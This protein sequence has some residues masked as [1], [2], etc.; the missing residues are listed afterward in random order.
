MRASTTAGI[1][2]GN[3]DVASVHCL[4]EALG[5]LYD[6]PHGLANAILLAPLLRYNRP[7][8][9]PRLSALLT[10]ADPEA[11]EALAGADDAARTDAFFEALERLLHEI[12]IPAFPSLGIPTDGYAQTAAKAEANGSNPSN[13]RTMTAEDYLGLLR[14]LG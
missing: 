9:D 13:A 14:A 1:A 10:V 6:V 4:S 5:G 12:G 8:V 7:V 3:A 11:D 2:F